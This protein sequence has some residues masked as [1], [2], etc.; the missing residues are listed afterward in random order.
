MVN[1]P[2]D[3]LSQ[4]PSL[5]RHVIYWAHVPLPASRRPSCRPTGN[6]QWR[7]RSINPLLVGLLSRLL[8]ASSRRWCWRLSE[9]VPEDSKDGKAQDGHLC[10]L[11]N[12]SRAMS[13]WPRRAP[14][15]SRGVCAG[16]SA[17]ESWLDASSLRDWYWSGT[18]FPSASRQQSAIYLANIA[19]SHHY[20]ARL[21]L[22]Y[23]HHHRILDCLLFAGQPTAFLKAFCKSASLIRV[24]H[25]RRPIITHRGERSTS[26]HL[27]FRWSIKG[28]FIR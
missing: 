21:C 24:L 2:T 9:T 15:W 14:R 22:Y 17:L 26:K 10:E 18:A 16:L 8:H 25:E 20:R 28:R 1:V 3:Q 7:A 4:W 12:E 6:G 13:D 11:G 5:L 27:A 19:L 23:R